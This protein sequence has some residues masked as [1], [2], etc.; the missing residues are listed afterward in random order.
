MKKTV[1][2]T[3]TLLMLFACAFTTASADELSAVVC[4]TIANKGTIPVAHE[5]VQVTDIDNDN[6]LTVNDA[7]YAVHKAKYDGGADAGYSSYYGDYGLSL[8]KLWGDN[9]GSFGYYLNNVS[10][11][12]LADEVKDGDCVTASIYSD[13]DF[14]SD[15]YVYFD[16]SETTV[17]EN[18]EITLTLSG[19]SY[20]D[21]W[22]PV[23]IAVENATIT[24]NG[25]DTEYKTDK[26]GKVT[27]KLGNA[28][29]VIISAKSDTAVLV[30]P[31]CVVQ[32]NATQ[33]T[34]ADQ[35]TTVKETVKVKET[36]T[37]VE[38][39]SDI[40]SENNNFKPSPNTGVNSDI[41][42]CVAL[43]AIAL[44][45]IVITMKKKSNEK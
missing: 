13:T 9:S 34:T 29:T 4:V 11:W 2:L 21:N 41:A 36:A 17:S 30:P 37:D 33:T 12:S 44:C 31:V 8:Q 26:D 22:N 14:Y 25:V 5:K 19:A 38:T 35:T 20:D 16:I 40:E 7:L 45:G 28:G 1:C 27:I 24:A 43:S 3:I 18:E 6:A 10:C 15:M 39:V 42:V 23:T 32:V